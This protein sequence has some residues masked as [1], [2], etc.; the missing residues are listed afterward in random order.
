MTTT[1]T[2]PIVTT[3]EQII[4]EFAKTPDAKLTTKNIA[5]LVGKSQ[6][7]VRDNL[8]KLADGGTVI[9]LDMD[10][11]T[12]WSLT[13]T[14]KAALKRAT[15]K[16]VKATTA[17]RAATAAAK[18]VPAPA[19]PRKAVK[20]VKGNTVTDENVTTETTADRTPTGRR[21]KGAIDF[22]IRA[23]FAS[24]DNTP[25]GSYK[26]AK[27]IDSRS[28]AA[29]VALRRMAREGKAVLVS[30]E[31]DRYAMNFD[32]EAWNAGDSE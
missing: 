2:R 31:P 30:Q 28:G 27:G 25:E 4:A 20:S 17:K 32:S 23:Y 12:T 11:L 5:D 8:K 22:E 19:K 24:T 16:A 18:R 9:R 6:T 26:V 21:L 3:A 1:A 29:Y 7:T 13:P 10:G 14:R 15:R